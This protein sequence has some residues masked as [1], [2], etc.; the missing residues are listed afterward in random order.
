MN[1]RDGAAELIQNLYTPE[2]MIQTPD[3]RLI[4][5]W[6][7][8]FDIF[9][10]LMAGH[11]TVLPRVWSDHNQG[12]YRQEAIRN[13]ENLA[14]L[15]EFGIASLRD[16]AMDMS[17]L[18]MKRTAG[19]LSVTEFEHETARLRQIQA[20]WWDNLHPA[21][22]DQP[23][24][25]PPPLELTNEEPFLPASI[26]T[27][28]RWGLNYMLLDYHGLNMMMEHQ[29]VDD[30]ESQ[31]ISIDALSCCRIIAGIKTQ[32]L[33]PSALLPVQAPLGLTALYLPPN[34]L[35]RDWVRRNM[36]KIEE[37]G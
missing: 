11:E 35:Y 25:V 23:T 22:L 32:N 2:S 21:L 7:V 33:P 20:N 9:A 15:V 30:T 4:F 27:G 31:S 36:A 3:I 18:I 24:E 1:H 37:Q 10:A 29:V 16:V 26:Y 8:R 19:F 17:I 28:I 34:F 13:P 14:N 6:F 5:D 12:Y